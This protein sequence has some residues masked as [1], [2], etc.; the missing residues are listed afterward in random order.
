[1]EYKDGTSM[2][3]VH[4]FAFLLQVLM[5]NLFIYYYNVFIWQMV[6]GNR[7]NTD[8]IVKDFGI[9]VRSELCNVDARV[10]PSPS[11]ILTILTV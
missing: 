6:E 11:V 8:D 3:S 9:E 7:Y 4:L 10:L 5:Y 1:M 2:V